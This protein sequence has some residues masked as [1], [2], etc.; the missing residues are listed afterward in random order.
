MRIL[1]VCLGNICRSPMAEGVLLGLIEQR[2]LSG[3]EVDSAGT[4]AYHAGEPPDPRTREVLERNGSPCRGRARQVRAEDFERFDVIFA[5]DRSN[6]RNLQRICPERHAHKVRLVLGDAD[7]EDPYY[8]GPEGF[9]RN[10]EQLVDALSA[11]LEASA[12]AGRR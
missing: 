9:Q 11:W 8:G 4:A 7:V 6:L 10:Y 5:M 2:G 3:I 1:F 12:G